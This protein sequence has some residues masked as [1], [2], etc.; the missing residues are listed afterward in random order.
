[1]R[2]I[3]LTTAALALGMT[4]GVSQA[5]DLRFTVWTGSEAH[6][7]MLNEFADGFKATHPNTN[8]TFE[9]IPFADYVQ[10]ISLQIGGGNPPDMGWMLEGT[11]PTFIQSNIL[12]DVSDTLQATAN[13]NFE[14]LSPSAMG[15][16][17]KDDA[18]YGVPF[19]TSPFVIFYNQS[20]LDAAGLDNP[21][22]LHAK[23]E[24]TWGALRDMADT[25]ADAEQGIYG[26]ETMDGQGYDGRVWEVLVPLVRSYGGDVWQGDTC[27]L[28]SA[29]A[30]EAVQ[31]YHDM[32]FKDQS[33]VP[34]G[35]M[36]DFFNG[37]A[38]LTYTQISR[39]SKLD[40]ADFD[41]GI[42]PMPS[43][44]AGSAPI[45]GQAAV[46]VF[47]D[48]PNRALAEEFLAYMTNEA[49]VARMA[50]FFPPARA[51]VLGSDAFLNS[52]SRLTPS[53]MRIVANEINNGSVMP[54]HVNMPVIKSA[55][56]GT[57]D[58]LWKADADIEA[59]FTE[60]CSRINKQLTRK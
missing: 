30:V 24:W 23:G 29:T 43:G 6:L 35:E 9:T 17:Q 40:E 48:S 33:A 3:K 39:A 56:R 26:F 37:K 44:K 25:L 51:S 1:M 42:A 46:V 13:Y 12:A 34:P 2:F 60:A 11:A 7:S 18:V 32:I 16:W 22:E 5:D 4:A 54:S 36:G 45:I 14:D 59:V 49:G 52:N 20:L 47:K 53:A 27:T 50:E 8:I 41:W 55:T 10:K 31:V 58:K 19:S 15:L 21:N 28:N 38:A 57:F